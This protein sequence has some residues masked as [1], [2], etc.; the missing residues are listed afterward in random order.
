MLEELCTNYKRHAYLRFSSS[1]LLK[2]V[3]RSLILASAALVLVLGDDVTGG[4]KTIVEL[5]VLADATLEELCTNYRRQ[6]Y[7]RFSSSSLLKAVSRSLILAS[8]ALVLAL[9]DDVTGG[10]KAMAEVV[11]LAAAR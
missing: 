4:G 8:A 6:A 5:V 3:S 2:A 7:L 11:G 9:D 10:G 1:S